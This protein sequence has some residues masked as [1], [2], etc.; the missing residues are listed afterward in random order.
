MQGRIA[1]VLS[2]L[3]FF[4]SFSENARAEGYIESFWLAQDEQVSLYSIANEE[5]VFALPVPAIEQMAVDN[6]TGNAW[7][8]T[9]DGLLE[10]SPQAQVLTNPLP[11]PVPASDVIAFSVD[12]HLGALWLLEKNRLW[13]IDLA[14]ASVRS[15]PLQFEVSGMALDFP[16][17][18]LHVLAAD[19]LITFDLGNQ[20]AI[21]ILT[22][23]PQEAVLLSI[24]NFDGRIWLAGRHEVFAISIDGTLEGFIKHQLKMP[25]HLSADAAGGVWVADNHALVRFDAKGVRT[26]AV[27]PFESGNG[28]GGNNSRI[29]TVVS[30]PLT[31]SAWT[32]HNKRIR[33][34]GMTG[35]MTEPF[36]SPYSTNAF[37]SAAIHVD[38][39]PP[40]LEIED[41]ENGSYTNDNRLSIRLGY[42]D[43]GSGVDTTSFDFSAEGESVEFSCVASKSAAECRPA[44]PFEDGEVV[45]SVSVADQ[46]GNRSEEQTVVFHVDTVPPEFV[47][48]TPKDG[49]LTGEAI[50]ILSVSVSEPVLLTI[51]DS[52]VS[53]DY[54][55]TFSHEVELNEGENLFSLRATDRAGNSSQ[56]EVRYVLDTT[57]PV[58]TII[59][60]EANLFTRADSVAVVGEV[61]EEPATVLVAGQAVAVVEGRFER[62]VPLHEGL[63]VIAVKASDSL[64]NTAYES[65]HVTRDSLPPPPPNG[66]SVIDNGGTIEIIGAPGSVDP[67]S[68]IDV[69]PRPG[70]P[71]FGGIAL[72]LIAVIIGVRAD[73]NG[74]FH[75]VLPNINLRWDQLQ[76]RITDPAGNVSDPM[77]LPQPEED[78]RS[79]P[80]GHVAGEFSVDPTGA[81]NY[82]IPIEV[83]RGAA[84][85]QPDL[86]LL[87]SS[88]AGNGHLGVGWSLSGLSAV[89]RCPKTLAQDGQI[90]SV[91]YDNRDSLC[92]DGQRLVIKSS[93]GQ[94]GK[95]VEYRTEIESFQKVEAF[96]ENLD[97]SPDWFRVRD[98]AGLVRLYG[99]SED[100]RIRLQ[101]LDT[102]LMWSLTSIEDQNKNKIVYKYQQNTGPTGNG[103]HYP[104]QIEWLNRNSVPIGRVDLHYENR[105]DTHHGY[106]STGSKTALTQRL[107]QLSV[108]GAEGE[109]VRRYK[110]DY[111]QSP[112]SKLSVLKS[113]KQ[114]VGMECLAA[115]QFGWQHYRANPAVYEPVNPTDSFT[116]ADLDGDGV[117][118]MIY[119]INFVYHVR[120]GKNFSNPVPTDVSSI[121]PGNWRRIEF[122]LAGDFD[123][124]GYQDLMVPHSSSDRLSW[125]RGGPDGLTVGAEDVVPVGD[126]PGGFH[127]RNNSAADLDGDGRA[128][129]L[130]KHQNSLRI[131][132][133][134][135]GAFTGLMETGVYAV[136][137]QKIRI[138]EADGDGRPE[139]Y[140]TKGS[141]SSGGGGGWDDDEPGD[142]VLESTCTSAGIWK[143][144]NGAFVRPAYSAP[145]FAEPIFL[146]SNGDGLTDILGKE[147]AEWVL[148]LNTGAAWTKKPWRGG[149]WSHKGL[150]ALDWNRD[151]KQD[152]MI[153]KYAA[154]A[155]RAVWQ[156]M[157]SSGGGFGHPQDSGFNDGAHE[158]ARYT[159]AQFLDLTGDGIEDLFFRDSDEK[160]HRLVRA[161]TVGQSMLTGIT[162]GY[163]ME[164]AVGYLPLSLM[165]D[166]Y[167]GHS[168]EGLEPEDRNKLHIRDFQSAIP[169]VR[170]FAQDTGRVL[171]GGR[172]VK[173]A[174]SYRYKGAKVDA[175]GRGFL[176]FAEVR[177]SNANTGIN[178]VNHHKQSFPFTGMIWKAEQW[179]PPAAPPV[180][181]DNDVLRDEFFTCPGQ[182]PHIQLAGGG[183]D[184]HPYSVNT[185]V[186]H[187]ESTDGAQLISR[188]V[189]TPAKRKLG[190][191]WYVYGERSHEHQYDLVTGASLKQVVTTY[192]Y[193][194][195]GNATF[196]EVKTTDGIGTGAHYVRTANT[197]ADNESKWLLGRLATSK[198]I[199]EWPM[200]SRIERN[201]SFA[202][203][204]ETGQVVAETLE[205]GNA[206]LEL[207]T[208]Y[209]HDE[210]GNVT[211]K[212]VSSGAQGIHGIEARTTQTVYDDKGVYPVRMVNHLGHEETYTWNES[213][214][215]KLTSTGPNGLT[216]RWEYDAFGRVTRE[217]APRN[218]VQTATERRWCGGGTPCRSEAA[219]I[220][221]R[222]T[223]STG[224][225]RIVELDRLGREVLK[226]SRGFGEEYVA[227]ESWYDLLGREYLTSEPYRLDDPLVCYTF[228]EY[229]TL[230]R[231]IREHRPA[232]AEE[233]DRRS[234]LNVTRLY[235]HKN[236]PPRYSAVTRY[237]Y[238][239]LLTTITPPV[240]EGVA[241]GTAR[242]MEQ[243]KDHLGNL[244]S[245]KEWDEEGKSLYTVFA[246]DAVGNTTHV[247][248]PSKKIIRLYYDS[249][250]RKVRMQDPD[251][252]EW[253]YVHNAL[254]ELVQQTD[255]KGQV[256]SMQYDALGRMVQRTEP[257]GI[258]TWHYD[259]APGK[260]IGQL[261][262][263]TQYDGYAETYRYT[264]YGEPQ[265]SVKYIDGL[266]YVTRTEYD[267]Y[268]RVQ[269]LIYPATRAVSAAEVNI[270]SLDSLA[271]AGGLTLAHHYT[272]TGMLGSI[273]R[274]DGTEY[275]V[276][277]QASALDARGNVLHAQLGNGLAQH[278]RFD[279]ATGL[280][281]EQGLGHDGNNDY[282]HQ[283]R[284]YSWDVA[285]NLLSRHDRVNQV[286]ENFQYDVL[287]RLTRI[288]LS[289]AGYTGNQSFAYDAAGNLKQ[290]AN[291]RNFQYGEGINGELRPHAVIGVDRYNGDTKLDTL[292]YLY[293]ANGNAEHAA[294]R[295]ITWSSYNKPTHIKKGEAES[296]FAYG[297]ARARYKHHKRYSNGDQETTH[298]AGP[299]ERIE[300]IQ[301]GVRRT[302]Y[303]QHIRA[304][305]VVIAV[306][307]H[308]QNTGI[309]QARYLHRD[310]LGSIALITSA[311]GNTVEQHSFDAWG[312]ATAIGGLTPNPWRVSPPLNI[313]TNRGYTGHE[314][315]D[316]L[317]L[318]HMNGRIYDQN[319][320]RFI[321]ADP[322]VQ[323]PHSTQGYNRYTYVGNNPLSATDPS[324]YFLD[325]L[326][327]N[328]LRVIGVALNFI[329]GCQ[330][331]CTVG[332]SALTG[333]VAGYQATGS[334]SGAI[335]GAAASAALTAMTYNLGNNG[336]GV[337]GPSE[338]GF[339]RWMGVTTQAVG[340]FEPKAAAKM[341][342]LNGYIY[343]SA[344][345][346]MGE[347]GFKFLLNEHVK[348][349]YVRPELRRFARKNGLTLTE[350]NAALAA[351]S[352]AGN[353]MVGSRYDSK[354]GH[355]RGWGNRGSEGL[356][357]DAVDTILA[358]QGLPT[359][360]SVEYMMDDNASG[361][362][363]GHSLGSLDANNLVSQGFAEEAS[364]MALPFG[365][366]GMST[367]GSNTEFVP[368]DFVSGGPAGWILNPMATPSLNATFDH[369][370]RNFTN[371]PY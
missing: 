122:S 348:H 43:Y 208:T 295:D 28:G 30:H 231:V 210:F 138:L 227:T 272:A 55:I 156:V 262:A 74:A 316:N 321:S 315:L 171:S 320:G 334:L 255:A 354:E 51:N 251:M 109:H 364:M 286:K 288:Q 190:N 252:G 88:R 241:S 24:N 368:W 337:N 108:Y 103:E 59:Q 58:I 267:S 335:R 46:A 274:I 174:T 112:V 263:V 229:D 239:G 206:E 149:D 21:P 178:T 345:S 349:E 2:A 162:D 70:D 151:G 260:G 123:G 63:N 306:V 318:I 50:Q 60:P 137:S 278:A 205:P 276:Y 11:L 86:A 198:V 328:I 361:S 141:C 234:E 76:I 67:F 226:Y 213:L 75:V 83:P 107:S 72:R 341:A 85:M 309:D 69:V 324:G 105:T 360:S 44:V 94:L 346:S 91:M 202:Y 53:N 250:G 142:I 92:L 363:S 215:V 42:S 62:S 132:R 22:T 293:D 193:D 179:L 322:F 212:T 265:A 285:G 169:V 125:L 350:L 13:E 130:I 275:T 133:F 281:I 134:E 129:L 340:V 279:A 359:A 327:D 357:F 225:E 284:E 47:S 145:V 292:V 27:E 4:L 365:N 41:P 3:I 29:R 236:P 219:E 246:Y 173:V 15:T 163:G 333:A 61:D 116:F 77:P 277:W 12:R 371:C 172:S 180:D 314:M 273:Q 49:E 201:A 323:F 18:R 81:A 358:Y 118:D 16:R 71:E 242:Q 356:L 218:A 34:I 144:V 200:V 153:S 175:H 26:A 57:P 170:F 160:N 304:G 181:I 6:S 238:S 111:E 299:T 177:A 338:W 343:H 31:L 73:A 93:G 20:T 325:K 185:E 249:R 68:Q 95:R 101:G 23:L 5:W 124:D 121:R 167:L 257:E 282:T 362:I 311:G 326:K 224:G 268:G 245:V 240:A 291:L 119:P 331:W 65:L 113:V 369:A 168:D 258:T 217:I 243:R 56:R 270:Q 256:T 66:I 106:L 79:H 370:C 104:V 152:L 97:G 302:E 317:G 259:N 87:Y 196:I 353:A 52:L 120:F 290:K 8:L 154:W 232:R 102:T 308:Y 310:H 14:N 233:C 319:I 312:N 38:T 89:T 80:V 199:H 197:Y 37:K 195:S 228:R 99:R 19:V 161:F 166:S 280:V 261:A 32:H 289:A 36:G 220:R 301:D 342:L 164:T 214:G 54:D 248:P 25:K 165:G 204:P 84:G 45:L 184:L 176:G 9:R 283:Y 194:D 221:I 271:Q 39:T 223:S 155:K 48:I 355:F 367:R 211:S 300:Q 297:P 139:V 17:H 298:Y 128:E 216:T 131:V 187:G 264:E 366:A 351:T 35:E 40:I 100:S 126:G 344:N 159:S 146:D 230:N 127:D 90:R 64:G 82:R 10:V 209:T 253:H 313:T 336:A 110:L 33:S 183:C 244:R 98:K 303:R 347:G 158:E 254:G 150:R 237:D 352:F 143:Y 114:C 135:N 332:F 1:A 136:S 247:T 147:G 96:D 269:N 235:D 339:H 207:T 186:A 148:Y 296:F 329:P 222:H 192:Q 305:G 7:L 140:L 115:T 287:N 294:G 157:V 117:S 203:H 266:A 78:R 188:T 189:T 191:A 307:T 330:F 182:Q